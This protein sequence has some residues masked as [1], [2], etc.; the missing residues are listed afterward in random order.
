MKKEF[1]ISIITCIY[2]IENY[3]EESINS[4]I[5]QD[6][7]FEENVQLI[8]VN[9]GSPDNS[10]EI[11]LKYQ[12]MYPDNIFYVKKENGGLSSAKNEG[13]KHIQGKYVNFFDGDDTLPPNTLKEVYNFF[14]KNDCYVDIV[15]IPLYFFESQTGLHVKYK[16]MGHKNRVI[17]L[18]KEPSNF[19]ISSA[20][21]FYKKE[22][23]DNF[24]F[25]ESFLGEEDTE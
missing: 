11:C 1:K 9:D 16:K 22:I 7:G 4:I 3:L 24:R 17:N 18:I 14:D 13:L 21:C 6:I 20:S 15:A 12:K 25:D 5:N 23:F 19:V 2:K 10:E 8:L